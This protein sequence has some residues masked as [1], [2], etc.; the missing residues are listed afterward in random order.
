MLTVSK[1]HAAANL[2]FAE[3]NVKFTQWI[4]CGGDKIKLGQGAAVGVGYPSV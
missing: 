3:G 2:L 4:L 1:G